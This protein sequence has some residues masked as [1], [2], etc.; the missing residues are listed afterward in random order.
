MV[1][2]RGD[3]E[4]NEL[5][6]EAALGAA[7]R[8]ATP[9][10]VFAAQ[11]VEPGFVGPVPATVPVYADAELRILAYGR[12]RINA[13]VAPPGQLHGTVLAHAELNAL[14]QLAADIPDR[15]SYTLYTSLE[16]CPMCLGAFY[17][18]GVRTLRALGPLPI[19]MSS[20]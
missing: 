3:H 1:L 4:L 17:M 7:S 12:N 19:T 20:A 18:S 14:A 11:G 6:L 15:H 13:A 9:E 10:E 2:V 16:P 8:M 5:K